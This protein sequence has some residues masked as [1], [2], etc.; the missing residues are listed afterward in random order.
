MLLRL[1]ES[2]LKTCLNGAC[3]QTEKVDRL[4][5]R[6]GCDFSCDC[7]CSVTAD[8]DGHWS[9]GQGD[10]GQRWQGIANVAIRLSKHVSG[11]E[12]RITLLQ[13]VLTLTKRSENAGRFVIWQVCVDLLEL[14]SPRPRAVRRAREVARVRMLSKLVGIV[15]KVDTCRRSVPRRRSVLWKNPPARVKLAAKTQSWLDRSEA[16]SMLAA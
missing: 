5:R 10:I 7:R 12:T 1:P 16:T 15:L 13:T 11:A 9:S 4:Q 3:R 8:T 14:H 2:Q 6:S